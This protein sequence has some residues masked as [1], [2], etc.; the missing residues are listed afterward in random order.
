MVPVYM[1]GVVRAAA[2]SVQ[3]AGRVRALKAS[4]LCCLKNI[5]PSLV[6]SLILLG[7]AILA[8]IPVFLG[9]WCSGR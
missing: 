8:S 9:C 1:D 5:A 7:F 6:Y 4:F 3:R 2:G